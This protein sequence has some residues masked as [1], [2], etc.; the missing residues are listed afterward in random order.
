MTLTVVI[1]MIIIINKLFQANIY[2]FSVSWSRILPTGQMSIINQAGVDYYNNLINELLANGIEP[3][4]CINNWWLLLK[5]ADKSNYLIKTYSH[6]EYI[7]QLRIFV[8]Y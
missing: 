4:V 8:R 2:R 3:M 1:M 5:I 7:L 6:F